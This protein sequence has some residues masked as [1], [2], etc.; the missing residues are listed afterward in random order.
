LSKPDDF[1]AVI[2]AIYA[3]PCQRG[4]TSA[5]P[6]IAERL[7]TD[8]PEYQ[9]SPRS[10]KDQI[11]EARERGLLEPAPGGRKPGRRLT[12]LGREM[13]EDDPPRGYLGPELPR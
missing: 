11:E 4:S 12:D 10:L 8:C 13:L 6:E 1:Y 5:T 9:F 7:R 2:A 3:E